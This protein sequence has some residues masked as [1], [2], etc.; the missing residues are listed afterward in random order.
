VHN[1]A[2]EWLDPHFL[3]SNVAQ[4]SARDPDALILEFLESTYEAAAALGGWD[5]AA[6]RSLGVQIPRKQGRSVDANR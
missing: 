3:G 5:L 4:W 2:F 1:R 6:L